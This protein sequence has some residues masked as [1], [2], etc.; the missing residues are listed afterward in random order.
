[1]VAFLSRKRLLN[2]AKN[3]VRDSGPRIAGCSAIMAT[4]FTTS[5]KQVHIVLA[6]ALLAACTA[7]LVLVCS[8]L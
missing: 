8:W 6:V 5:G 1:L 2:Q 7:N 3:I 4:S